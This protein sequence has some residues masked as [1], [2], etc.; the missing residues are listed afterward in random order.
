MDFR[1]I[2]SFTH[3]DEAKGIAV[4]I[5]VLRACT[6]ICY[7]FNSGAHEIIPVGELETMFALKKEFPNAVLVGER[8]GLK[9][10]GC[11]FGNSPTEIANTNLTGKTVIMTTS[12][13]TQ[14]M[15]NAT[16]AEE[17]ITGAFVNAGAIVSYIKSKKPEVVSFIL[18]DDRWP[19]NEDATLATYII[20]RLNGEKPDFAKITEHLLKHPGSNGFV[21]QPTLPTSRTDFE[22]AIKEDQFPFIVRLEKLPGYPVLRKITI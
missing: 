9:V 10:E 4:V 7:A 15:V 1:M 8:E 20:D 6:T 13:G 2:S 18:T 22:L 3:A 21:V 5:D 17:I 11:D 14:G 12:S 19:D 16:N